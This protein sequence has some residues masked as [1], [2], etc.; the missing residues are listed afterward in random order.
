MT[1]DAA[2]RIKNSRNSIIKK[3]SDQK[4]YKWKPVTYDKPTAL[5]YLVVR[6][7]SDYASLTQ[8][9]NEI[10]QRDKEFQPTTLFDFGSGVGSV[11]W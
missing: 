5:A 7:A 8:I 1:Q 10:K 11:T 9:F 6:L 2:D 4:I 3:L